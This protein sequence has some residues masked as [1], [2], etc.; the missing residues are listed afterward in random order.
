MEESTKTHMGLQY[1]M[2]IINNFMRVR[3]VWEK[4]YGN[5]DRVHHWHIIMDGIEV[6]QFILVLGY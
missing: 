6:L 1:S 3:N 4:T 5:I 2:G